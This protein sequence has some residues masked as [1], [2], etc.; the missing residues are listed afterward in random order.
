MTPDRQEGGVPGVGPVDWQSEADRL[1]AV[2]LAEGSPTAWFDRLYRSAAAGAV[3][4]PWDRSAPSPPVAARVP[5]AIRPGARAV[6]VG[7]G[8]GADAEFLAGLGADVLAFDVSPTAVEL[9]AGRHPD[10]RVTY[11]QAD[12]L[13]LPAEW[14]GAFDLVVEVF[15]VQAMPEEVRPAATAAVAGLVAPGG[16][17]LVVTVLRETSTARAD[18]PPWPLT[19]V[20]LAAFAAGDL[21]PGRMQPWPGPVPDLWWAEFHRP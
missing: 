16:T 20:Q 14:A 10:S 4:M 11:R 1:A 17:L 6:V 7:C 5:E 18:G 13:D 12:L 8:L 21:E 15:T 19:P 3:P 2:S 9:A